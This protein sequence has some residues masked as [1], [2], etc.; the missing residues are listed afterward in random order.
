MQHSLKK[1]FTRLA[2][3]TAI[4]C[5]TSF[6]MGGC[7]ISGALLIKPPKIA[8]HKLKCAP[9]QV[10]VNG[11]WEYN[12]QGDYVWIKGSCVAPRTGCAWVPGHYDKVKRGNVRVKVWRAGKW[13]C[14]GPSVVVTPR[15]RGHKNT[16]VVVVRPKKKA[17]VVVKPKKNKPVVVVKPKKS[18]PKV[19]VMNP[20]PPKA[21][22]HKAKPGR[23]WLK[24][25]YAWD[26]S[27]TSYK[28]I[29]GRFKKIKP[30]KRWVPGKYRVEM[31]GVYKV[32]IWVP[33]HWR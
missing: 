3:A 20:P 13:N 2:I 10:R 29:P 12:A 18:P 16:P 14:G 26:S 22:R 8:K 5:G 28:W 25:H 27:T 11:Y 21:R 23:V 6:L 33:G 32:K 15:K 1:R 7:I 9:G 17:V 4:L 19:I 30:G 24:G 31:R